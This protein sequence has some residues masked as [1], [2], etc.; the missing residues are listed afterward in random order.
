MDGDRERI[1]GAY[2]ISSFLIGVI[3]MD[4][5]DFD[6]FEWKVSGMKEPLKINMKRTEFLD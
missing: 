2:K 1:Q 5:F 4:N 6:N 3:D